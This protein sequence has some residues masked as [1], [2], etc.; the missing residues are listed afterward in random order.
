MPHD[1]PN[2]FGAYVLRQQT[3]SDLKVLESRAQ[4]A[5]STKSIY[6]PLSSTMQCYYVLL[7]YLCYYVSPLGISACDDY[8]SARKTK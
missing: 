6:F 8:L 5:K 1:K 7:C 2:L 4:T 3:R